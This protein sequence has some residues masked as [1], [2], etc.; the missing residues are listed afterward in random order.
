MI[1]VSI[2]H[3]IYLRIILALGDVAAAA[4]GVAIQVEALGY[5]PGGAFQISAATLAGQ[6]LGARDLVRAR[7]SVLMACAVASAIMVAA[8]VLFYVAATPLASFFLG[9][10]S[11]EVVPLATRLLRIVAYA[12]LPLAVT[13]V[14]VGALRGAGDTRWPLVLNVLGI[15][16]VRVPLAVFLAHDAVAIP[17]V[18]YSMPGAGLGVVGAWY[19][20]VVDIVA[21]CMLMIARFRH[22]AWQR[23]EV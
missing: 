23:I 13:M 5:M 4:H 6:Y 18:G 19:A 2:C 20:A 11:S 12:M 21:R 15:I 17:L 3:L 1:L 16:M 8:G 14:L 10:R 9:G 22:D 7:R